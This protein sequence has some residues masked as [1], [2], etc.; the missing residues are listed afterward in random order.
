MPDASLLECFPTPVDSPFVIEHVIEEFTSLCPKTGH[1][2]FGRITVRYCPAKSC[3]ELKSLKLYCQSYRNE[4]IFY[5]AVTNRIRDDLAKA[6]SPRWLGAGAIIVRSFAR[7]HESNLKKQGV[8]PLI[9]SN[10]A[11][12][13]KVKE[14]DEITLESVMA[15]APGKPVTAILHHRGGGDERISLKHS[16]NAEQMRA[17][18]EWSLAQLSDADRAFI[19][20]FQ[21]TVTLA[22][23]DGRELLCFHGSPH[24]FDDIIFPNTSEE[25]VQRFLGGSGAAALAGGHTHLQQIRRLGDAIFFNPGSVGLA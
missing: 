25:D 3:V 20:G 4:G 8:L 2:D 14:D 23:G 9:F 6:M 12:Y 18:R 21:P 13:E 19:A 1:P 24:S 5:E 22:L 10:P 17:I 11:D 15:I 7:I 16:L